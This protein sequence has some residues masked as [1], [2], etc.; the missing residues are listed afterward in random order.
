MSSVRQT[1]SDIAV[2]EGTRDDRLA[3]FDE[4]GAIAEADGA[5]RILRSVIQARGNV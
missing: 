3:L 5:Q 4:I 1:S 2:A